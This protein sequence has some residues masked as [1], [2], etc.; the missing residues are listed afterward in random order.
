MRS[1]NDTIDLCGVVQQTP[2]EQFGYHTTVRIRKFTSGGLCDVKAN[3][4]ASNYSCKV[5]EN[6]MA[7]QKIEKSKM[8]FLYRMFTFLVLK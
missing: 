8:G 7:F 1:K 2:F 6:S 3:L 5:S 4:N